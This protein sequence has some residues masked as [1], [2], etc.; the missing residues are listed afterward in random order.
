MQSL[1][2]TVERAYTAAE[3][4]RRLAVVGARLADAIGRG[5][6]AGAVQDAE[7][8]QLRRPRQFGRTVAKALS[9]LSMV[10]TH[11]AVEWRAGDPQPAARARAR[12][13]TTCSHL[14][15]AG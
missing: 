4:G 15:D 6:L 8:S 1:A 5:R 14:F 13:P 2:G 10:L 7:G 12:P 3:P 11:P 9:K